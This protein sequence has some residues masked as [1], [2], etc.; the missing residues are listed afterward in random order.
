[1]RIVE[2]NLQGADNYL[3]DLLFNFNARTLN[4]T[5]SYMFA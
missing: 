2:S 5:E 1:M 4:G 3:F